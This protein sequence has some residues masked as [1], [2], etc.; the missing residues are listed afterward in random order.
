VLHAKII[1][2]QN[3]EQ[4]PLINNLLIGRKSQYFHIVKQFSAAEKLFF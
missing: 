1:V 4:I 2:K 3:N